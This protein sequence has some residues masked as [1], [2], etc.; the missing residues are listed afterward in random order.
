MRALG[1]AVR[2]AVLLVIAVALLPVVAIAY[3]GNPY[4]FSKSRD[5]IRSW[6]RGSIQ[7]VLYEGKLPPDSAV[8]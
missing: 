5:T 3:V 6:C 2:L 1:I 8:P 4:K 7:W